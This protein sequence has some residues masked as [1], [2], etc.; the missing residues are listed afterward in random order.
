MLPNMSESQGQKTEKEKE[1]ECSQAFTPGSSVLRG[2]LSVVVNR[3][4]KTKS[5]GWRR[6]RP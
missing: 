3:N 6:E 2:G 4:L 1:T 5:A